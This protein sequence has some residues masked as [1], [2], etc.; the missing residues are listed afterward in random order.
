MVTVTEFKATQTEDGK[1]FYSL[2]VQG[3]IESV[4]SKTGRY[5]LTTRSCWITTTFDEQMCRSL[6]GT[7]LPGKISKVKCDPYEYTAKETGEV[8][9][10]DH[11]W[12][13]SPEEEVPIMQPEVVI[14][15]HLVI[16]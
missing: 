12:Q 15:K 7:S 9:T 6:L 11:E 13:Y 10:L 1:T 14:P 3:G 2:K 16:G 8:I 5:Y 4:Q